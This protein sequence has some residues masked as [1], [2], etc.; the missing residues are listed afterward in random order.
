V[1]IVLFLGAGFSRA[2]GLPIM[3]DFFQYSKD[4]KHLTNDDK[5]FLRG[6]Q[7]RAQ[8]GVNM[9]QVGHNNLEDIL[10][11]CL[12]GSDYGTG[13][14][15]ASNAEYKKLCLILQ[16]I[17]RQINLIAWEE[18]DHLDACERLLG[19]SE[20]DSS[21]SYELSIITTNYDLMPEFCLRMGGHQFYLP[22]DWVSNDNA[23][24]SLYQKVNGNLLCKLHGSINWYADHTGSASFRVEDRLVHAEYS[25]TEEHKNIWLPEISLTNYNPPS[26]PIIVPPTLFKMQ[27]DSRFQNIWKSAGES[28]HT[29]EKLIFIGFSFPESDTHIRYFLAANLYD[30][31]DLRDIEIVDPNAD[32]IC[33]HLKNS[34]FGMHF[35]DR[36][37]PIKGKWEE[38]DYSI[39]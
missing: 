28:L 12:A 9:F 6:L 29:A 24:T 26:E 19:I 23:K 18:N 30:N 35:K 17:Y 1:K 27:T 34:R 39:V 14:P 8:R 22:G 20:R 3:K 21:P 16:K 10:S 15:D 31:V 38:I 36:L 32:D 2:W 7:S 4:S 5:E 13:Y 11:F 25:T 33:N 37:R